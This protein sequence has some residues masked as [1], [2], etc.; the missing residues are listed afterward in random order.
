MPPKRTPAQIQASEMTLDEVAR[1]IEQQE[2]LLEALKNVGKGNEKTMDATQLSINIARFHPPTYD[3][4]GEPKLLEKWHR[5][6]EALMEMVKCPEDMIVEQVVYYLRGEAAVWWQNVKDDA[7]AYYQ[8]EGAIPWSGLKS[9]M[10]EQFVPEHIRH[11]MRSDFE[12]FT[13]SEEM[14]VTD[15][16]HRFLELSRYVEDMQLGQR[17]LALHFERGL[18]AKIVS[19]MPA[20]VATDL[21]E[22]YLRAGQAERMVDLSREIEERTATEKRKADS[23]NNNQPTNKKGNFNHAKAFSSGAGFSGGSRGWGKNGDRAVSDN[24]NL[25]CFNCGGIGHKRRECTS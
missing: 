16:Y 24:T 4:V 5:E 12:S 25:T 8:A 18:S 3:G 19:R 1:M 7:R 13:M 2:A 10:R 9:A 17:G 15:Y 14:T 20:G 23:G 11:K 21:K 6:I 22:V